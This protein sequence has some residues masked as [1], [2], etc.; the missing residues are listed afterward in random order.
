MVKMNFTD[1]QTAF[2]YALYM[3]LGSYFDKAVCKNQLLEKKMYVQYLEQREKNQIQM[4]NICI[5]FVEKKLFSL[6]PEELWKQQVEVQ[7]VP[8]DFKGVREIQFLGPEFTLRAKA[9]YRGMGNTTIHYEVRNGDS[10]LVA[11]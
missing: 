9:I 8:S 2:E 10:C 6:L 5:R 3:M 1:N 7:I 11:A 4:E